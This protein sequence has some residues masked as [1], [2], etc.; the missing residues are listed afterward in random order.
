MKY[1]SIVMMFS[2]VFL[3]CSSK[4]LAS[5]ENEKLL[6][7][8]MVN[9]KKIELLNDKDSKTYFTVTYLNPIK[10]ELIN[11]QESE[12]FIIGTYVAT[13]EGTTRSMELSNFEVNDSNESI[14]VT[15]LEKDAPLLTLISSSNPWTEYLLVEA[16][17][18]KEHKM[19]L[20]FENDRSEKVSVTF[21][22][23]F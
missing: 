8:G 13:G 18:H 17:Y 2:L 6:D 23:D 15:K 12:Q 20:S 5:F 10:H 3:G 7:F 22:K 19:K 14:S 11:S 21:Q 16:P 9:S 4:P 1:S